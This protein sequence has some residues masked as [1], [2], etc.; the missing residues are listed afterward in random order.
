MEVG[1]KINDQL[2]IWIILFTDSKFYRPIEIQIMGRNIPQKLSE[3]SLQALFQRA[4]EQA[5][6]TKKVTAQSLRHSFATRLL[7]GSTDL[8]YI[9]ALSGHGSSRSIGEIVNP[10]DRAAGKFKV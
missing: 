5:G 2:E 1:F 10:L 8:R 4:V 6:I 9:Q 7:E 3:R